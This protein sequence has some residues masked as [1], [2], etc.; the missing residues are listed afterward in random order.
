[1]AE[2]DGVHVETTFTT[3]QHN[4]RIAVST[5]QLMSQS[6]AYYL[7]GADLACR[8]ATVQA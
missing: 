5:A 8:L 4:F 7:T 6:C 2:S 3:K 1:M